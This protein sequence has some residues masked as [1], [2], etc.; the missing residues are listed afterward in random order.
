M[1]R[2]L[3]LGMLLPLIAF[4]AED[5]KKIHNDYIEDDGSVVRNLRATGERFPL[6]KRHWFATTKGGANPIFIDIP[7]INVMNGYCLGGTAFKHHESG[8]LIMK[9]FNH[10]GNNKMVQALLFETK[11]HHYYEPGYCSSRSYTIVSDGTVSA[12]GCSPVLYYSMTDVGDKLPVEECLV[13][14]AKAR[15][16]DFDFLCQ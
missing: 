3:L 2:L 16:Y 1:K 11:D 9:C 5:K 7:A 15:K 8:A 6:T 4:G 12:V 13:I 10:N 14:L